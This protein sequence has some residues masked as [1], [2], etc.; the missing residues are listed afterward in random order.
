MEQIFDAVI[1]GAGPTGPSLFDPERAIPA[2]SASLKP[3]GKPTT[4]ENQMLHDTNADQ[5]SVAA[6]TTEDVLRHHLSCFRKSDL[7]GL[8]EDYD[9]QAKFFTPNGIL[10]GSTAIREFFSTLLG[11]FGKPGLSFEI[12]REDIEGDTFYLVWK[13]DTA[14]NRYEFAT[15]TFVLQNGKI[16]T[17]TFAGKIVPKRLPR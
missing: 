2:I 14:D 17:Q 10:R 11:E 16:V 7:S 6:S 4:K 13:A 9:S 15:D 5:K 1:V 12:L 8:M 3:A